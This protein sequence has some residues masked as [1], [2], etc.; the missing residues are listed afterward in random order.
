MGYEKQ[1]QGHKRLLETL[2][3]ILRRIADLS[4]SEQSVA[5][6]ELCAFLPGVGRLYEPARALMVVGKATNG[7]PVNFYARDMSSESKRNSVIRKAQ[8]E[9]GSIDNLGNPLSPPDG[10]KWVRDDWL[11]ESSEVYSKTSFWFRIRDIVQKLEPEDSPSWFDKIVWSNYYKIAPASRENATGTGNPTGPL[12]DMQENEDWSAK[13]LRA[14]IASLTPKRILFVT[15]WLDWWP[16][17]I[18]SIGECKLREINEQGFRCLAGSLTV[19]G[20]S[21]QIVL[22]RHPQG[23]WTDPYVNGILRAFDCVG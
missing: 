9:A 8:I 4:E 18:S 23:A 13:F 19:Q 14:E 22:T 12:Q 5:N 16:K 1:G 2:D 11:G 6:L 17:A 7:W 20:H 21:A 10:L 3:G 15:G